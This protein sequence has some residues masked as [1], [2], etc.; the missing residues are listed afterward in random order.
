[1]FYDLREKTERRVNEMANE[2]EN[3]IKK[4]F[5]ELVKKVPERIY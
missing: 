1:M 3:Q 4:R 5:L 2:R